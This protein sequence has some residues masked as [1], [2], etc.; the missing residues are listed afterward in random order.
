MVVS[1]PSPC[2][3]PEQKQTFLEDWASWSNPPILVDVQEDSEPHTA[4]GTEE[5]ATGNTG[6]G[7][8]RAGAGC[9]VPRTFREGLGPGRPSAGGLHPARTRLL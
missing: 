2:F 4:W 3:R 1:L 9:A 5:E 7:S 8:R 6:W